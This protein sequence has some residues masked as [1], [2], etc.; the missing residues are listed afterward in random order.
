MTQIEYKRSAEVFARRQPTWKRAVDVIGALVL[1]LATSPIM[2]AVAIYIKIV[3]PGEALFKQQRVGRGGQPFTIFKFRTMRPDIDVSKHKDYMTELIRNGQDADKPML[4]LDNENPAII[5]L[6]NALRKS[7][8]DE[9]PQLFNV[10][11]GDMS[12]VGPRPVIPYEAR[13]FLD[14]HNGRFD[15]LPGLTGL[16][17]VMGKNNLTFNEMIRLDV[18]Y[19]REVSPA[20]DA[21]ILLRTPA[22]LVGQLKAGRSARRTAAAHQ[23]A[24][25]N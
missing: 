25:E 13:E 16:W 23:A 11:K 21:E 3:S 18:R 14:W 22:V 7:A 10:L 20:L 17:Q 5:P 4:K 9:L 1:I 2:L 15:V 12:L 24:Q 19:S 8:I 6:G